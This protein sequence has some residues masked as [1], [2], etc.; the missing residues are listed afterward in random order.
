MSFRPA[1]RRSQFA[2]LCGAMVAALAA[3][4]AP[5][6]T[7]PVLADGGGTTALPAGTDRLN[8][9]KEGSARLIVRRVGS[10]Q[11][12]E[13]VVD[14]KGF[15]GSD[16]PSLLAGM[17]ADM[18]GLEALGAKIDA[19]TT[20]NQALQDRALI[21]TEFRVYH[22]VLPVA[23]DVI[24]ADFLSNVA[25]TA[26][27]QDTVQLQSYLNSYN[28]G[29]L[30]PIITSTQNQV[31]I[32]TA[33]TTGVSA[34]LLAY[35]PAEWNADHDLLS[36]ARTD[37]RNGDRALQ[38]ALSDLRSAYKFLR[39]GTCADRGDDQGKN[40]QGTDAQGNNNEVG[41]R[42]GDNSPTC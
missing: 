5:L 21:F 27:D 38:A 15:L 2:S 40:E 3:M 12:A 30:G 41:D 36:T 22:L 10:L 14:E 29:V 33:A 25:A 16:G 4:A 26:L 32:M 19:D 11:A 1:G 35:T 28:Q 39:Q 7:T 42:Q 24:N 6:F 37:L 34:Q 8:S 20:V 13:Q 18:S 23:N 9:I 31:K 17:Q